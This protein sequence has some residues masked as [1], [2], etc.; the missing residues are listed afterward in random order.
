MFS[1]ALWTITT[2]LKHSSLRILSPS[3]GIMMTCSWR[4]SRIG[5]NCA[6]LCESFLDWLSVT[7]KR[8]MLGCSKFR[9]MNPRQQPTII[10]SQIRRAANGLRARKCPILSKASWYAAR[11]TKTLILQVVLIVPQSGRH[12]LRFL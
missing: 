1:I 6:E 2:S 9:R 12:C 5:K 7:V 3:L 8:S 10:T 11:T 4:A